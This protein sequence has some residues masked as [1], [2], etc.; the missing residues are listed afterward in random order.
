MLGPHLFGIVVKQL[1][2]GTECCLSQFADDSKL[3]ESVE[4]LEV[5][6]ALQKDLRRLN[7]GAKASEMSF[8]KC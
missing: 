8:N 6:K 2:K 3:G 1:D 4:L 7:Q 5:R